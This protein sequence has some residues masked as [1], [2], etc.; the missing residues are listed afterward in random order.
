MS[1]EKPSKE[2]A[3]SLTKRGGLSRPS[4]IERAQQTR[5]LLLSEGVEGVAMRLRTRLSDRISPA[6]SARLR[7]ADADL[8]RAAEIASR[9]WRLPTPLPIT[10][11]EPLHIAWVSVPP[12]EGAGGFTTMARLVS[13]LEQAGHR[14]TVYLHD[15]HGWSIEQHRATVRNWWPSLGADVR[16]AAAGI[17]DA[18]AIFATSWETAYRVLAA[19]AKGARFYLV[20]DFEPWFHPAGSEAMLAEATYRFGFH[21]LTAGPWLAQVM[22]QRYGMSA[23]HFDFGCDLERY[24]IE[25]GVERTGVCFY[26][27]PSTPRRAFELGVA[28]LRLLADRHPEVDI[29]AYGEAIRS[30]PLAAIHHGVLAPDDLNRLYNRCIAGLALSASNVSL[31]PYEMLA[32]GCIPVVNDADHN[33]LVLDNDQVT[34]APATPFDLA[35]ALSALVERP[36]AERA[37]RAER[38]AASVRSRSW[39]EAGAVIE[40]VIQR[41]VA[42]TAPSNAS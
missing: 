17:D 34:Y 26:A 1:S 33:Q 7:V 22:R 40:N 21:G 28:T 31:V 42:A 20:Q 12:G 13:L 32:A 24:A 19:P 6:G 38:A 11:G 41:V 25:P 27:R 2:H 39:A 10:A 18:H 36:A 30:L 15:R 3:R 4:A 16:D 37:A 5:R 23:D 14:C 35:D 29:H 8:A 9:G